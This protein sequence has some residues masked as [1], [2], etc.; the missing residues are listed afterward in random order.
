MI[1]INAFVVVTAWAH[2]S[3]CLAINA[4]IHAKIPLVFLSPFRL[5]FYDFPTQFNLFYFSRDFDKKLKL[6]Y[7]ELGVKKNYNT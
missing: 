7:W 4:S 3:W 2:D 6:T 5:R 1:I